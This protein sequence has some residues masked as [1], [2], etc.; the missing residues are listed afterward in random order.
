MDIK[1]GDFIEVAKAVGGIADD[2]PGWLNTLERCLVLFN[3][4]Y[5]KYNV[6]NAPVQSIKDGDN[7]IGAIAKVL[8]ALEKAGMGDKKLSEIINQ[9]PLTVNQ[10]KGLL[11]M[12]D[13]NNE[14]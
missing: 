7:S 6:I 13:N 1:Q 2:T 12:G 14:T 10:A 9:I 11:G 8:T 4:A 5:E 3:Q